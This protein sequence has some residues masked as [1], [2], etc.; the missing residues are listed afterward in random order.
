MAK[1]TSDKNYVTSRRPRTG[2][3]IVPGSVVYD[4]SNRV[5]S[6]GYYIGFN[7]DVETVTFSYSVEGY[8][9][10][11]G[12]EYRNYQF[13]MWEATI[14]RF[15]F[16][17]TPEIV[18]INLSANTIQEE[19]PAGTLIGFLTIDG[20]TAPITYTITGGADFDKLQIG[21][22]LNN[23]LQLAYTAD[24]ADTPLEVQ[25]TATDSKGKTFNKTFNITITAIPYANIYSTTFDGLTELIEIPANSDFNTVSF[26]SAY[27]IKCTGNDYNIFGVANVI[28]S[29]VHSNNTARLFIR[30]NGGLT[31]EFHITANTINDGNWHLLVHT[32]DDA[33]DTM[34]IYLDNAVAPY[35]IVNNPNISP[36]QTDL[37]S[38][39]SLG[40]AALAGL[41][42][43]LMDEF[44][45]WNKA[46]SL[47]EVQEMY[48]GGATSDL[49][50]HS[51]AANL[52][53]W[54]RLGDED[55]APV[56][57][58]QISNH[59]GNMINMDQTNFSTDIPT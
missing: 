35:T 46:L 19:S 28:R 10:F 24:I 27:W 40:D 1:T 44:S 12:V 23:E 8:L 25:I 32:Y 42:S 53:T 26:S 45:W 11:K 29:E 59:D 30:G 37:I 31:K 49:K 39:I 36:R 34:Q 51:A 14:E 56:A 9:T 47:A 2:D 50:L 55:T 16:E 4:A 15:S 43:G 58:D 57:K 13:N 22:T 38:P 6:I 7:E 20:G 3:P 33:T 17:A 41:Y 54:L 18:N 52:V 5:T 21:G 48:N